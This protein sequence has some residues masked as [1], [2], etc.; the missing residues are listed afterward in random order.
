MPFS[1]GPGLPTGPSG[2]ESACN[3]RDVGLIPESRRS[4][5][6]WNDYPLKGMATHSILAW[7]IPWTEKPGGPHSPWGCK[8]SDMTER[9]TLSLLTSLS[10]FLRELLN[11]WK[12]SDTTQCY[13]IRK[14][15]VGTQQSVFNK[16]SR[17]LW[18][19]LCLRAAGLN[20]LQRIPSE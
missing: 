2:K 8:E 6:E 9:Q 14:L 17:W 20:K 5:G 16:A 1:S 7:R 10:A 4:P 18:Y 12:F 3:A 19:P 13:G 11:K 15:G